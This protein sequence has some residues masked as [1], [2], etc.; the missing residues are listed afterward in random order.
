MTCKHVYYGI[1]INGAIRP[2]LYFC[3]LCG[4]KVTNI[5]E[6]WYYDKDTNEMKRDVHF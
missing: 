6:C 4:K 2:D 3:N 5:D 1:T